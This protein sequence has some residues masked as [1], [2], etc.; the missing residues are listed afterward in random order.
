MVGQQK[1]LQWSHTACISILIWKLI[2]SLPLPPMYEGTLQLLDSLVIHYTNVLVGQPRSHWA[3]PLSV[4]LLGSVIWITSSRC[5]LDGCMGVP[6]VFK[7]NIGC[8]CT[9]G[10]II[11]KIRWWSRVNCTGGKCQVLLWSCRRLT[12]IVL[13]IFAV[14]VPG[15]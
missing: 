3:L 11:V 10:I 9:G 4:S 13:M 7:G 1:W 6:W 2:P 12:V 8:L 15:W 5:S 14:A